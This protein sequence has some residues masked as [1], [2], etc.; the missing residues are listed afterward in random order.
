[1]LLNISNNIL[2]AKLQYDIKDGRVISSNIGLGSLNLKVKGGLKTLDIQAKISSIKKAQNVLSKLYKSKINSNLD[3]TL[4][5]KAQLEQ[6]SKLNFLISS[7]QLTYSGKKS[8]RK[9]ENII[10]DGELKD[11]R[12][13]IK[14]Y[15]F[16][17]QGYKV[18]SIKSSL[19]DINNFKDVKINPLWINDSLLVTGNYNLQALSGKLKFKSNNFN[20]ENSD[21]RVKLGVDTSLSVDKEKIFA[22]GTLTVL[23]GAIKKVI[24]QKNVAEN[25][26]I[27][28]LQRQKQRESTDFAKNIKLNIKI[29]SKNG[30]VYSHGRNKI[31]LLPNL[32]IVKEYNRLSNFNGKTKIAKNSYYYLNGKKLIVEKG[33][34]TFKGKSMSPNLN[35]ILTYLGREYKIRINI[36]GT[37]TRPVLYFSSDP[38]LT[39]D[40]ILAYLLFDDTSAAGTH[41]QAAM[42][43]TIGG[44]IAKS[45]LGSLGIK[46]DYISIGKNSFSIGKS[47]G[48][49][50]IIYYSQENQEPSIKTRIDINK[51][52][53]TEVEVG[54]EKQSADIIFSKEY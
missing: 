28:I 21:L 29:K 48:K 38:S 2:K 53:H 19:I 3:G 34:I 52:I 41:S 26:D 15:N 17:V 20:L 4:T 37:P 7:P 6:L 35:I 1:M 54:Q 30:I 32:S 43:N 11:N 25:E 44:S 24:E 31:Q 10:I 27:I 23:D 13:K 46:I 45:F 14:K 12:V 51:Y 39:K 5:L 36:V 33:D 40:Q 42:L 8:K 49:N 22:S 50:M 18:F 16:L 47:L 9:I